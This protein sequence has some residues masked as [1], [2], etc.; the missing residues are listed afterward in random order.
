MDNKV[1]INSDDIVEIHVVGDQNRQSVMVMGD[2]AKLLLKQLTERNKPALILDDITQMKR[3]DTPARQTVSEL[4]RSLP[5]K[6]VA[7]V[8][9]DNPLMRVGTQLLIQA[10]G[11]GSKI[12]FFVNRDK[13]MKWLLS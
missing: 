9:Q 11:M 8:G 3:T 5:Y 6:K 12:K 2:Q 7:M 10:I 4:A 1:F 13:A